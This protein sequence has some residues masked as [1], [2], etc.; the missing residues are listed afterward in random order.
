MLF[1]L[2]G[3]Y[4]TGAPI[5]PDAFPTRRVAVIPPGDQRFALACQNPEESTNVV[6][7]YYQLGGAVQLDPGFSQ[8]TP[9]LLS[10]LEAKL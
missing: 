2:A 8:L 7:S 10:A 4:V 9:R 5:A 1:Q 6:Y 3:P